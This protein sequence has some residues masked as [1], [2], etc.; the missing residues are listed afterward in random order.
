MS[1]FHICSTIDYIIVNNN[2]NNDLSK[3]NGFQRVN[4]FKQL[5]VILLT[6][7]NFDYLIYFSVI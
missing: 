2:N 5:I 7:I 4:Q 6:V 3:V 1:K